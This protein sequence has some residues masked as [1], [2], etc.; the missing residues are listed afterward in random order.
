MIRVVAIPLAFALLAFGLAVGVP[1]LWWM[2]GGSDERAPRH[3]MRTAAAIAVLVPISFLA[4]RAGIRAY[5]VLGPAPFGAGAWVVL[6]LAVGWLATRAGIRSSAARDVR[7]ILI[8]RGIMVAG[9]GLVLGLGAHVLV[10]KP[11]PI[12]DY[13]VLALIGLGAVAA[14]R[15]SS[16]IPVDNDPAEDSPGG[17]PTD[18]TQDP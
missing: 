17:N 4:A 9:A 10:R 2:L 3:G 6:A 18:G 15:A 11:L 5:P 12:V 14:L 1:I 13:A 8:R 7:A 16:T